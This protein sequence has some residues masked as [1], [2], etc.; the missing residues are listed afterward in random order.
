M[1]DGGGSLYG[2]LM[3]VRNTL[4]KCRNRPVKNLVAQLRA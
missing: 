2:R 4:K 1:A 3:Y